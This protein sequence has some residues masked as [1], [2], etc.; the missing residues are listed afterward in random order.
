MTFADVPAGESVFLDANTF[1]YHFI[2]DPRYGAA[3]TS[4]LE[5]LERQEIE[6]WTSPHILAEVSHRLMTIEACS[7]FGRAYQGV[8]ARLSRH[9]EHVQ[10][11]HR[12][13][14]AIT[15]ILLLGLRVLLV[16]EAHIE[17]AAEISRQYGLLTNDSL[18]ITLMQDRGLKNLVSNDSD[19]DRVPGILRYAP[20]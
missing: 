2:S 8:A 16:T 18:L 11:L 19:F 1:V 3:C 12:F 15:R 4:L 14:E 13:R 10:K 7:A 9:P 17:Q 5:R 6:G 20:L